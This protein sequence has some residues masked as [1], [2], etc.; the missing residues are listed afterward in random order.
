LALLL[1]FCEQQQKREERVEYAEGP[2]HGQQRQASQQARENDFEHT[3]SL[4]AVLLFKQSNSL[5]GAPG[6]SI[7]TAACDTKLVL[8]LQWKKRMV[9]TE[10]KKEGGVVTT[11]TIIVDTGASYLQ[12]ERGGYNDDGFERYY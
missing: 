12:V 6:R 10:R 8:Y 7:S 9:K 2:S 1:T 11:T 4:S 5:C 3:A